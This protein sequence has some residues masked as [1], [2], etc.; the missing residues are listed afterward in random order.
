MTR[1]MRGGDPKLDD[2]R[3]VLDA[4]LAGRVVLATDDVRRLI[5]SWELMRRAL[6]AAPPPKLALD[7]HEVP[8]TIWYRG[9]RRAALEAL[10]GGTVLDGIDAAPLDPSRSQASTP[11][12]IDAEHRRSVAAARALA[13]SWEAVHGPLP[14]PKRSRGGR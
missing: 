10:A 2:L 4:A 8:H 6:V 7:S 12:Q 9:D 1:A 5:S 14:N 3:A 11:D 13:A